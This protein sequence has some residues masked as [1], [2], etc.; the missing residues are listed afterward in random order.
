MQTATIKTKGA[1]AMIDATEIRV[2]M[3]RHENM[4]VTELAALLGKSPA[5]VGRWLE[6]GDM[7]VTAAEQIIEILQIPY[8]DA[9]HIFFGLVVAEQA[10]I[11]LKRSESVYSSAT[12][13]PSDPPGRERPQL[14]LYRR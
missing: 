8:A 13:P 4:S 11:E 14:S 3:T 9:C 2:Y 7:P 6:K 12:Y 5:T 10:T 1:D